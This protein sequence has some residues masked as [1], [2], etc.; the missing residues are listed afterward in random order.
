[1]QILIFCMLSLKMP[2]LR[3]QNRGFVGFYPRNG[4]QYERDPKS[5]ILVRK[6]VV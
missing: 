5:H 1:M 6:H 3:P 2:I 4:E